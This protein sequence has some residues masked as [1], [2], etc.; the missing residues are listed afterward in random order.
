MAG[1]EEGNHIQGGEDGVARGF[2]RGLVCQH[3]RA[4]VAWSEENNHFQGGESG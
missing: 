2:G 1:A 3:K 4:T